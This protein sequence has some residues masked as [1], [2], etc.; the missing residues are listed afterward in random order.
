MKDDK[1]LRIDLQ[2]V[3]RERLPRLSHLIPRRLVGWMERTIC[4]EQLNRLLEENRGKVGAEFCRGV[5]KSLDISYKVINEE[6]MPSKTN[7]RVVFVSNHP[8]GALDGMILI[9]FVQRYYGGQVWFVVNDLLMH[10]TPLRPVFLPINKFGSQSRESIRQMDAAFAG[11]DPIIIFPAG[12]VSRLHKVPFNGRRQKMVADLQWKKTFVTKCCRY[13]RDVVPLFFSGTNSMRFYKIANWRKRLGLRF[14][15]EQLYLPREIFNSKG[16]EFTITLGNP[17]SWHE[18]DSA[19][20][21]EG[22][23]A[24]VRSYVY[25]LP[26]MRP[27]KNDP[28]VS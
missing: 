3:L 24:T 27:G 18:M 16:K 12:L 2:E 8:L 22:Y 10:V 7:R 19:G 6:Y 5:F 1:A 4:Q 9:D 13:K 23:A 20:D 15:I 17:L 26:V 14:N 21:A 25:M 11:D 28:V